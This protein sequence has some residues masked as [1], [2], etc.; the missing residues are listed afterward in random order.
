MY[1]FIVLLPK[2]DHNFHFYSI[3]VQLYLSTSGRQLPAFT[4]KAYQKASSLMFKIVF[5]RNKFRKRSSIMGL[6]QKPQHP[7]K[8]DKLVPSPL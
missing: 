8:S 6:S 2:F 4:L 5:P 7:R 1:F 3:L